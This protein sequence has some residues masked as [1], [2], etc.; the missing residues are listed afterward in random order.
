VV[1]GL[2]VTDPARD[3]F[4]ESESSVNQFPETLETF[5][6]LATCFVS[7]RPIGRAEPVVV[8]PECGGDAQVS[9]ADDESFGNVV[10]SIVVHHQA[11]LPAL[12]HDTVKTGFNVAIPHLDP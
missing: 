1:V 8:V 7:A 3:V 5:L 2:F 9:I 6:T 12:I 11:S 4:V 10:K